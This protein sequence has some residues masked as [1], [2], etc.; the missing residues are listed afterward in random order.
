LETWFSQAA[1]WEV[2]VVILGSMLAVATAGYFLRRWRDARSPEQDDEKEG[3]QE[4][5]LVSSVLGLFALL[6]GFTFSLAVD[7]FDTRRLLVLEE[8]NAIGTTY[9]R[10]QLLEAPHRERLS[11]LLVAYADNRLALGRAKAPIA[12]EL[13]AENDRLVTNLWQATVAAFPTIR[14]YDF[15]SSFLESMNNVIDLDAARKVARRAHVPFTV[16]LAL[17]VYGAVSAGVLGYVLLGIR[18]RIAAALL[19]ALFAMAFLLI[20]D[21]DR[22]NLGTIRESQEPMERLYA[23]LKAQPPAVF[24]QVPD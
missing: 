3:G 6:L 13:I 18:G 16:F 23:S 21:I 14:D 4:G 15:S 2:G 17:G 22:P 12:A 8:A 24:D 9:L 19:L 7:R 1:L 5:Y 10:S 20:I 11:R